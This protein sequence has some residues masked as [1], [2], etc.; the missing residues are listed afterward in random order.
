MVIFSTNY[1]RNALIV[2]L[3]FRTVDLNRHI[4]AVVLHL[5]GIQN[6]NKSIYYSLGIKIK[7]R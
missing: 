6:E 5:K 3:H 2:K 4:F 7:P 1:F